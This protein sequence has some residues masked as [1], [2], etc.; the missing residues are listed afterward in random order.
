M[1]T[2]APACVS[3]VGTVHSSKEATVEG[4]GRDVRPEG[5]KATGLEAQCAG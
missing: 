3:G 1:R 2:Y 5:V 4:P